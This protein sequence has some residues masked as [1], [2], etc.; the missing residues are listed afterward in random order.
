MSKISN[1]LLLCNC[2]I[3]TILFLV[4][5][6]CI[7]LLHF[8]FLEFKAMDLFIVELSILLRF[9]LLR[10]TF[11]QCFLFTKRIIV[12]LDLFFQFYQIDSRLLFLLTVYSLQCLIRLKRLYFPIDYQVCFLEYLMKLN[13]FFC[14]IA[15]TNWGFVLWLPL[16]FPK[17]YNLL[18]LFQFYLV[19]VWLQCLL[20]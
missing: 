18:Q 17:Y 16:C 9:F 19:T 13:Y 8:S 20:D 15:P 4:Y 11:L 12:S 6:G 10:R 7:M 1:G 5:H 2:L 14:H 3:C